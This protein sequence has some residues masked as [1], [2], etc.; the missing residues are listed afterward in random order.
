MM[1]VF[2]LIKKTILIHVGRKRVKRPRIKK[3][4]KRIVSGP[5]RSIQIFKVEAGVSLRMILNR[6]V[7]Y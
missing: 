6:Q 3:K 4:K 2:L 5:I 7:R 1:H